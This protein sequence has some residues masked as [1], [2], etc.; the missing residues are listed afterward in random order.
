MGNQGDLDGARSLFERAL[1]I[2][3]AH[4]GPDDVQVAVGLYKLAGVLHAQGDLPAAREKLER[5]V[6]IDEAA[7]GATKENV[8]EWTDQAVM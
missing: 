1:A 6:R 4:L 3:E 8:S 5:A 7:Y 2:W